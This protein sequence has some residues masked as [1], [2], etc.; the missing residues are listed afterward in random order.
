MIESYRDLPGDLTVPT[1]DGAADHLPG[2]EVPAVLL[3]STHGGQ[4]DLGEATERL[5]V[6]Y[7]HPA[8]RP[9]KPC[10]PAGMR[11]PERAAHP[12][13]LRLPLPRTSVAAAPASVLGLSAK[14]HA[15]QRE[16]AGASTSPTR[17]A[18]RP[19]VPTRRHPAPTHLR[20]RRGAV[21]PAP[22]VRRAR[23]AHREGLL[24]VFPRTATPPR[25]STG[26]PRSRDRAA[27][28]SRRR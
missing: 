25:S 12:P 20:G 14:P 4:L 22:D 6:V 28:P 27:A 10:R 24:P 17:L 1:D 18:D 26:W 11:S 8:R 2:R 16:F 15:E 7:A 21:L 13:E 19:R 3:S 23:A 9:G 5:A